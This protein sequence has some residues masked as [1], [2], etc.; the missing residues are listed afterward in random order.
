MGKPITTPKSQETIIEAENSHDEENSCEAD[1]VC[2][3][4][5]FDMKMPCYK[6]KDW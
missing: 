3:A 1:A 5:N 4:R 6:L 2:G